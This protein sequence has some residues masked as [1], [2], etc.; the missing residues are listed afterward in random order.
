MCVV[1]STNQLRTN[2]VVIHCF[3]L[4]YHMNW[5]CLYFVNTTNSAT[6]KNRFRALQEWR[7]LA[8]RWPAWSAEEWFSV[9]R[10]GSCDKKCTTMFTMYYCLNNFWL[11]SPNHTQPPF[12]T[13]VHPL[14]RA[15][16]CITEYHDAHAKPEGQTSPDIHQVLIRNFSTYEEHLK[17]VRLDSSSVKQCHL[18]IHPPQLL[19]NT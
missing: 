13:A 15:D 7:C 2:H 16:P 6:L 8:S 1:S 18:I 11:I 9:I 5:F 17:R 4:F 12:P 3:T 10:K 14:D 19:T